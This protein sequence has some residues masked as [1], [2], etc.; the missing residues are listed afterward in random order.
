MA[1]LDE[2]FDLQMGKTRLEVTLIT[3]LT[4]NMIGYLLLI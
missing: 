3:G 4:A 1:R 2:I